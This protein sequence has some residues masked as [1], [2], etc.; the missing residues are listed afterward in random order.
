MYELLQYR[1]D[2]YGFE[3]G[4]RP[5]EMAPQNRFTVVIGRNGTGKSQLLRHIALSWTSSR[6]TSRLRSPRAQLPSQVLAVTNL[7]SDVFPLTSKQTAAEYPY[8]YLG[9]RKA[10]NSVNTGALYDSTTQ[11]I[12]SCLTD[13]RRTE[14]LTP[15]LSTLEFFDCALQFRIPV[16]SAEPSPSLE[17]LA[18]QL[19][20]V[21]YRLGHREIRDLH[22]RLSSFSEVVAS[23]G[24]SNLPQR[25]PRQIL[26]ELTLDFDVPAA[27]LLRYLKRSSLVTAEVLVASKSG[28]IPIR[29]LSTGQLLLL[30][31]VARIAASIEDNSLVLIDEPEVGL[32]PT[33]QSDFI[34]T[35]QRTISGKSGSHFIIAT[36]S[37]HVVSDSSDVLVPALKWGEFEQFDEPFYGRSIENLL[38]RVFEARVSGNVMVD[39]DLS[40]L[41][42]FVS[43]AN[44][45]VERSDA[46]GALHRLRRIAGP[47]TKQLNAMLAQASDLMG[48][49]S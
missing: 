5:A 6:E 2:K 25:D 42:K 23:K 14:L 49:Q 21:G 17:K 28:W 26:R 22:A 18:L 1:S 11:F 10:T 3:L 39:E 15:V 48:A 45:G 34:P 38:Y 12:A 41:L 4:S 30:S 20:A 8:K 9:L 27:E 35:L 37:P 31:T 46:E 13:P 19:E 43:S 24:Q 44:G 47:D 16:S 40:I 33:W 29:R 7:V 32:H 36:H